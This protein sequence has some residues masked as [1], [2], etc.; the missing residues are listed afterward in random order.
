ML[1]LEL[2]LDE[3]V[4]LTDNNSGRQLAEIK[5][6][7]FVQYPSHTAVRLGFN[8]PK[9]TYIERLNGRKK[10]LESEGVKANKP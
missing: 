7:S 1:V 10:D 6:T 3:T 4:I 5:I 2:K 8:A 9:T